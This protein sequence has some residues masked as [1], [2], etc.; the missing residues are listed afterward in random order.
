LIPMTQDAAEARIQAIEDELRVLRAQADFE[1]A[2]KP[3]LR[4]FFFFLFLAHGPPWTA[5]AG[6]V[7]MDAYSFSIFSDYDSDA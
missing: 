1:A 3:L 5:R 7:T 4:I 6:L 2:A